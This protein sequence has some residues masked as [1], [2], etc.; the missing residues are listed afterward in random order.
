MTRTPPSSRKS[1][2][3]SDKSAEGASVTETETAT[4]SSSARKPYKRP[5][6]QK[7][8]SAVLAAMQSP[9]DWLDD[10]VSLQLMN[11]AAFQIGGDTWNEWNQ[12]I[13]A[14]LVDKQEDDGS[15]APGATYGA[16]GGRVVSTALAVLT[17]EVYY[18]YPRILR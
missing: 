2:E 4:A 11:S 16:N 6:V 1:V 9:S 7:R 10:A 14:H 3:R 18:R 8:R 15:F 5:S 12:Q 13:R 17:L